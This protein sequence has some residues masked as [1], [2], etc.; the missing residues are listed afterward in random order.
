MLLPSAFPNRRSARFRASVMASFFALSMAAPR[1]L[2][3]PIPNPTSSCEAPFRNVTLTIAETPTLNRPL[4]SST[5][6]GLISMI[7]EVQPSKPKMLLAISIALQLSMYVNLSV[8]G[9]KVM[10][11]FVFSL[12]VHNKLRPDPTRVD[13][14]ST[15]IFFSKSLCIEARSSSEKSLVPNTGFPF[16]D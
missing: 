6:S 4:H 7:C 10:K 16:L 3:S 1:H 5:K 14:N 12:C 8:K 15:G 11:M 2:F 13:K 9:E